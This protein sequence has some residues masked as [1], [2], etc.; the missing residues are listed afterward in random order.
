MQSQKQLFTNC[1]LLM[2]TVRIASNGCIKSRLVHLLWQ[3][4]SEET[5][6]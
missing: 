4:T 5:T 6:T 1:T 3:Q 2:E